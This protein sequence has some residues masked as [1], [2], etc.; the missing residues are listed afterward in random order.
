MY[1][2]RDTGHK[3]LCP[4][5]TVQVGLSGAVLAG[6]QLRGVAIEGFQAELAPFVASS[7]TLTIV[8]KRGWLLETVEPGGGGL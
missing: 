3:A 8:A 4:V 1:A 2:Y 5:S 7:G 6:R